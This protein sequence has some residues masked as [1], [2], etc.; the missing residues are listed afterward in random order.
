MPNGNPPWNFGS[1]KRLPKVTG[2]WMIEVKKAGRYRITLR[3]FPKEAGK[4][5]VAVD[6][7]LEIAGQ[8]L[9]KRVTPGSKGVV[10]ELN[11][12]AGPTKLV[13]KLFD[14]NG[15]AGGAYFTEVEAR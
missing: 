4:P 8:T 9:K 2:P 10:F 5:V 13:T 14:R 6:A 11:L 12:P 15:K 1:I 3:Q 7:Q